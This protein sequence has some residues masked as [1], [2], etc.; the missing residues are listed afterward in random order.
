MT[1]NN[2]A[3]LKIAHWKV[4][5]RAPNAG[6]STRWWCKCVCGE[7]R[8]VRAAHLMSGASTSCGCV[9]RPKTKHGAAR[10]DAS[11]YPKKYRTWRSMKARCNNPNDKNASIYFGLLCE[12]WQEFEAFNSDVADPP[13]DSLTIDRIDNNRGYEPGNVRWVTFAEQHR[14]Q[15]NCK[16]ITHN[17]ETRLMSDWAKIMGV[18][19]ST[20][21]QRLKKYGSVT[22]PN[23]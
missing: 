18:A 17:G 11:T 5:E 10:G 7:K 13:S 15:R 21:S 2:L 9:R 23:R 19:P 3:G 1:L 12:R 14:N 6:V 8:S 4:L 22:L 20:M 16:W